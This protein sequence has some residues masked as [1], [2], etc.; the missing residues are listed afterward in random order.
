MTMAASGGDITP[1]SIRHA[2]FTTRQ[3]GFSKEE[4]ADFLAQVADAWTK[5]IEQNKDLNQRLAK[6]T[7]QIR[8]SVLAEQEAK[9]ELERMGALRGAKGG[10][11]APG[12][13]MQATVVLTRAQEMADELVSAA[14]EEAARIVADAAKIESIDYVR[15]Y[16]KVTHEQLR[17][18]VAG[19][20]RQLDLLGDLA[21]QDNRAVT[22]EALKH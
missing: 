5:K 19:L 4:V 13:T 9:A 10:P 7:E 12:D 17:G 18:V 21:N 22:W 20:A 8:R 2:E 14:E 16:A 1:I 6:A 15:T 3:R 11:Q